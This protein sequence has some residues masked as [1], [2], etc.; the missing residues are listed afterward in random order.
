M[1][2]DGV[3]SAA[4][5]HDVIVVGSGV[6]GLRAAIEAAEGG[7]TVALLAKDTASDSN[8]DLAQGGVAVA[9]SDEDEVGLH[10]RDT[11][12]AGDGL[13]EESA[14]SA[15]VGEGPRL[16]T[17]LIEWGAEFDREG[18]RLAF[19][20]EG[21]HS[22]RRILHAN[23]D[24]TGREILRALW[25]K[26][27]SL[28]TI[29]FL[30]HTYS[31]DLI[32]EDGACRGLTVLDEATGAIRR[33]RA[34]AVIL[35]TGGLGR[36]YRETTNPP[37][38]TGDGIAIAWRAGAVLRD[39]EF[40][41][42][43]PTSLHVAGAPRFL[44]SEALRGE[45]AI[46]RSVDGR[47]FMSGVDDRLELA[48]RDVVARAI[49]LEMRRSGTDHVLLDISHRG[50]AWL[51]KRFPRI[52][53][54]CRSLGVALDRGPAPVAPAAHSAMGGV[55]TDLDGR[56]TVPGLLA[57]G[58]VACTGVHGANRLA[59]NSLLEGLV[60][61]ARA[62]RALLAGAGGIHRATPIPDEVLSAAFDGEPP[63]D[64]EGRRPIPAPGTEE[65]RDRVQSLSWENLGIVRSAAGIASVIEALDAMIESDALTAARPPRRVLE[66]R[67]M[68]A[69]ARLI[70]GS[71][72]V[73]QESR[74]SHFR[75]DHPGRD[76]RR[77]GRSSYIARGMARAVIAARPVGAA[78]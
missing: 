32:L 72:I 29:A 13:C 35:A 69:V 3:L 39:M 75:E 57:A 17:Q 78:G 46:L 43:H 6:A 5:R 42:F 48:P 74:G 58:E 66:A 31:I 59:S 67:N 68:V 76:D 55:A 60:F 38:A 26:A 30:P 15:M 21:A 10:F 9:L 70:A 36:I 44:L 63:R 37:Q 20:R 56:T 1:R 73:R 52:T 33:L 77:Y 8:T 16:I 45:G 40:V 61:G 50:E 71:A 62:G 12:A 53:S 4:E 7:L 27:S 51:N 65:I 11:L 34:G 64:R 23:G 54:T 41:Q 49:F 14:V 47:R 25:H 18:T 2:T 22:A 24:A 19:T 28:E